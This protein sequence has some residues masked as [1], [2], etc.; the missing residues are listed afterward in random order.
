MRHDGRGF[1]ILVGSALVVAIGRAVLACSWLADL[2]AYTSEGPED[3]GQVDA[4]GPFCK[5]LRD[6]AFCADFDEEG[7]LG[8]PW[9]PDPL[10]N[11]PYVASLDPDA[12]T[13][14]PYSYESTALLSSPLPSSAWLHKNFPVVPDQV[15]VDYDLQLDSVDVADLK[16][17]PFQL[18]FFQTSPQDSWN[19]EVA[20]FQP[21]GGPVQGSVGLYAYGDA[22]VGY[23]S[24][25]PT[26]PIPLA[27][28]MHVHIHVVGLLHDAGTV[29]LSIDDRQAIV[30]QAFQPSGE[31]GVDLYV[32]AYGA[33]EAQNPTTVH[34][35]NV[36]VDFE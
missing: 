35:D 24:L 1:A 36:V 9:D 22:V 4:P 5:T 31:G 20:F 26:L 7:G 19:I 28:W 34:V 23:A 2:G 32:G 27:R 21:A 6:S 12:F 10:F 8:P 11:M 25:D 29:T 17:Y 13:S 15:D 30:P 3:A 16:S 18:N 14:P 33:P